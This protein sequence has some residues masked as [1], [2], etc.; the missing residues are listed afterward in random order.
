M[1][2]GLATH[3]INE[4]I[5]AGFFQKFGWTTKFSTKDF[6]CFYIYLCFLIYRLLFLM[7]GL[8]GE[9]T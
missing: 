6:F 1:E 8:V 3:F 4:A 2:A 9:I 7:H 5:Y